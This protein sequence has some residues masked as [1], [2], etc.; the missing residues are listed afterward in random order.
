MYNS[1]EIKQKPRERKRKGGREEGE[2]G[3]Q[4]EKRRKR[5]SEE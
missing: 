3:R 5:G 1:P 4:K 2:K